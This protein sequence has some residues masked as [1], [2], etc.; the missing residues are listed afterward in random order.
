MA[1]GRCLR[2]SRN[3][4]SVV[5]MGGFLER[6]IERTETGQNRMEM[7]DEWNAPAG[8]I[9]F[10]YCMENRQQMKGK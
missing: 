5:S 1:G 9:P 6:T 2:Q 7:A 8:Q 10:I 3:P 4:E